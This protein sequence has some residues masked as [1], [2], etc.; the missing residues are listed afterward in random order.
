MLLRA[1]PSSRPSP[2]LTRC[3]QALMLGARCQQEQGGDP[4]AATEPQPLPLCQCPRHRV[5]LLQAAT[6]QVRGETAEGTT[7]AALWK[8][9]RKGEH[10]PLSDLR[11]NR[12]FSLR[13]SFWSP[14][15]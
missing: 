4:S 14:R 1:D 8:A 10:S 15:S 7:A 6:C 11:I 12:K 9:H 3:L 5:T 2:G 13:I